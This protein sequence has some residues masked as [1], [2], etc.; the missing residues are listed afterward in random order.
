[1]T[2]GMRHK[3]FFEF[4]HYEIVPTGVKIE[5][6]THSSYNE[7]I[8]KFEDLGFDETI[9]RNQPSSL[10]VGLFLSVFVNVLLVLILFMDKLQN[11]GPSVSNSVSIG[12]TVGMSMWAGQLFKFEKL[13]LITGQVALPFWYS[14]KYQEEVNAF[15]ESLKEAR[16]DYFRNMYMAETEVDDNASIKQRLVWLKSMGYLS[17]DEFRER[18]SDLDKRKAIKGF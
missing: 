6:K 9:T 13:K 18:L 4:R 15:I 16:R 11:L 3:R 14:D 2:K 17:E 10:V 12:V 8:V 1:M 7:Q 5:F